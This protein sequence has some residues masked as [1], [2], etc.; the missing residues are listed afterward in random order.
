MRTLPALLAS[1][2]VA[3]TGAAAFAKPATTTTGKAHTHAAKHVTK[4]TM[5][6]DNSSLYKT[7]SDKDASSTEVK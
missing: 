4:G 6:K 2:I 1:V 7:Q 3:T 5:K